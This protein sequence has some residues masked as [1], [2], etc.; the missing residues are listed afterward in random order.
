MPPRE[1]LVIHVKLKSVIATFNSL[2]L[3]SAVL[4]EINAS[5]I[6]NYDVVEFGRIAIAI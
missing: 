5:I 6:R 1:V 4:R 2:C 3:K